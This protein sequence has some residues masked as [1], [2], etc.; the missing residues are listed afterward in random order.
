MASISF[1][2][3]SQLKPEQR[4]AAE[5]L[6]GR[7]LESDEVVTLDVCR[8]HRAP[9]GAARREASARLYD[10]LERR[11]ETVRDIPE[12]EIEKILD[13]ALEESRSRRE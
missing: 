12:G 3:A 10:I 5:T 2:N 8:P 1:F 6:L 13:E 7:P 11:A 9:A 4:Q